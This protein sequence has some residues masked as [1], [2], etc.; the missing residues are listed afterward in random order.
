MRGVDRFVSLVTERSALVV[1]VMLLL[2]VGMGAGMAYL[3]D[4]AGLDQF[5]FDSEEGDALDYIEENFEVEEDDTTTVQVVLR[6]DDNVLTRDSFLGTLELQEE[7]REDEEINR[8]L[9]T[10]DPFA[11]LANI[12]ATTAIQ[13]DRADELE[14]RSD[15]LE[16]ENETLSEES[17]ELEADSEELEQR[18]DELNETVDLLTEALETIRD[19]PDASIDEQWAQVEEAAPIDLDDDHREAFTAAAEELRAAL[20]AVEAEIA[21]AYELGTA[22]VLEPDIEALEERGE[23]LDETAALLEGALDDVREQGVD[24]DTAF[25]EAAAAAPVDLGENHRETFLEAVEMME[26]ATTEAEFEEAYELGTQGVLAEEIDALE[27]REEDVDETAAL[28]EGALDELRDD[29]DADAEALFEEVNEDTAIELDDDQRA[30]FLEAADRLTD[31]LEDEDVEAAFEAG[32]VGVLEDEF[33]ELEDRADE[34]EQRADELEERGDEL[35]ADAEEI[36]EDADE[37]EELDPTLAEQREKLAEMDD[38]EVDDVLSTVLGEDAPREALV[39]VPTDYDRSS[40]ETDARQ[41]FVTQTTE[42]EIVDGEAPPDIENSQLAMADLVDERFGDDAFVFGAGIISDE[43]DRSMADSMA[44]VLPLALLFVLVVLSIAYRDPLDIILGMFGIGLVLVWTFGFMGWTGIA[45]NQIMIAVPVLLVGLSIDYAI[46]VFMRHREQ[47]VDGQNG[48]RGS[49]HIVLLGL[50][51]ALVWVTVTAVL[52]FLSNLVSPVAP[53]QEF[54]LVSAFG[55]AATLLIFGTFVPAAKVG[56]DSFLEARG[57]DRR[58]RAFGTGGGAFTSVLAGGQ[59]AA[60]RMPV[61]VVVIVLLITAGGVYGAAQVDTT[62]EQ[63]DFIADEP[64]DWMNSLPEMLAPGEYAVKS[65]MEFVNDRFLRQDAQTQVLIEGDITSDDTLTDIDAAA[66]V[67]ADEGVVVTLSDGE[68]DIRSPLS[69][70]EQTAAD[71]ET[72]AETFEAAD[73]TGDD[74]PDENLTAVYD[75]FFESAPD[76][77]SDV[78]YRTGDGEYESTRMVISMQGGASAGEATD[79]TREV[80][81]SLD[82]ADRPAIATGQLVVFNIIEDELFNTVI[83]SLLI[84]MVTVFAF[85]MVA[86]RLV[87]GSAMLGAVTLTPIVM[88]VAWILGTMYL[89]DISFNVMTGTITSLT[90]GL[91]VAYNIHMSERYRLE[92]SRGHD[93]W[94]ALERGVTGT[95]GALLGSA[96][97]TAGGFGVLALAIL[98]PLQQFG[99]ITGLTIIYAFLGSVFV[100]PSF[101]VLW[102]RYFGPAEQFPDESGTPPSG[103]DSP[104]AAG[105]APSPNGGPESTVTEFDPPTSGAPP[106]QRRPSRDEQQATRRE[107]NAAGGQ[108]G[109]PTRTVEPAALEPGSTYTVTLAVPLTPGL[110]VLSEQPPGTPTAVETFGPAPLNLTTTDGVVNVQWDVDSE[111]V[112]TV[113]FTGQLPDSESDTATFSG[114]VATADSETV[115][116]GDATLDVLT[117]VS[118]DGSG[119]R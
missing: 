71:N 68:P 30:Q 33:D 91:G 1:V 110:T 19:D 20:D 60:K 8:T 3:D 51:A 97:T 47:R 92:L 64:A 6:S 18:S 95:G 100:L 101:L 103:G 80:A 112:A 38:D 28:L 65:N 11:D 90:I 75:A 34:L 108:M 37:L 26:G 66:D 72:F 111:S 105:T 84:T 107:S 76:E 88:T 61:V 15:E 57:W 115:V 62:F 52:G 73:T 32:T 114:T 43:I 98:P 58:K 35:E 99:I 117:G 46:H 109:Q 39:F 17:E 93:V 74:V 70:M 44:I 36:E 102:T 49:M 22:D 67:A 53:I 41:L 21:S 13:Q 2:S 78:I 104:A 85:L 25:E 27:E 63:E 40:T 86:Y 10:E 45:F 81:S 48:T 119:E 96:A 69:V 24:P 77:A 59:R 89:L 31:A 29:P 50:G 4:E 94:E 87:H 56:L 12:V 5:Q 106:V 118:T 113:R 79:A 14:Q 7:F 42:E 83:E 9:A 23:E 16:A 82:R 54:G 116:S 55:I